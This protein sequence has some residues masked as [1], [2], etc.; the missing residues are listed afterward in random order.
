MANPNALTSPIGNV[1]VGQMFPLKLADKKV[2]CGLHGIVCV[3]VF[4][5]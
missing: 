5:N 2:S 1:G 3:C 4:V